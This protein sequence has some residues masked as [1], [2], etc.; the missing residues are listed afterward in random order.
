MTTLLNAM[1]R[2]FTAAAAAAT[3]LTVTMPA[4]A[5]A[6]DFKEH[7]VIRQHVLNARNQYD[8]IRQNNATRFGVRDENSINAHDDQWLC[9]TAP[10]FCPDYHGTNG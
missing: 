1:T 4:A 7:A 3:I 9:K 2:A 10:T 8:A 5:L 6:H